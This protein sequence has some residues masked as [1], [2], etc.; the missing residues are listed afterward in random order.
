MDLYS[1]EN[2]IHPE[3]A[4]QRGKNVFLL[5][6]EKKFVSGFNEWYQEQKL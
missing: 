4:N 6:K 2:R 1:T 5:R 3:N